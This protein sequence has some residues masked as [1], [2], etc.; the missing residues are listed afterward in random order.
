MKEDKREKIVI[1]VGG[2]ALEPKGSDGSAKEEMI[3]VDEL[4]KYIVDIYENNYHIGIV[5]GSGPQVGRLLNVFEYGK[6]IT[7]PMPLDICTAMI[8]GY[9]GF[10]IQQGVTD[11]LKRR[12][13]S[14]NITN[15]P[16]RILI[17][18]DDPA[19]L[20]PQKP[21]GAFYTKEEAEELTK[22]KG[23]KMGFDSGRGYR[24]LV[25]A[26]KPQKIIERDSI[27]ELWE[28]SII[29]ACGGG[30]VPV[31]EDEKG[32]LKGIPAVLDKDLATALLGNSLDLDIVIFATAVEK[33][34]LN[35]N[36]A[37]QKA[38]DKMNV[39]EAL[40]YIKDDQFAPGSML[41]KVTAALE[42]VK[43]HPERRA[44]I[45]T[46]DKVLEAL[47]GENGTEIIDG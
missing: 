32:N 38:I 14:K 30:G 36:K 1:A 47:K 3:Y 2:N 6:N 25:S 41:P 46:I 39:N 45:T 21:I 35:F 12:G 34:Y 8:Q 13:Y 42:F 26:P 15:I 23:W 11:E 19:F 20:N 43:G 37:N 24:R 29:I 27:H 9:I 22:S 28:K 5:H 33:V 10:Q 18:K 7:P 40:G 16:T 31:I 17:D 44:Y 4:A